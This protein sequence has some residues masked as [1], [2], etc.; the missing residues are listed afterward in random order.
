M[1]KTS[2]GDTPEALGFGEIDDRLCEV[3]APATEEG[4]GGGL[5]DIT[6][7]GFVLARI[8]ALEKPKMDE[9]LIEPDGGS[10]C[11]CN[12]VCPCV[13]D[14]ACACNE[15]CTCDSVDQCGSFCSCVGN[16]CVGVYYMPCV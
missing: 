7:T 15:V 8:D 5:Q 12:A 6:L 4:G 1:N 14:Q 11:A 16:C 3:P 13:P 2:N 10:P 9:E